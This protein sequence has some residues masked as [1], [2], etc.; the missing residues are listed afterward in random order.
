MSKAPLLPASLER[1]LALFEKANELSAKGWSNPEIAR[2]LGVSAGAVRSWARG[3]KPKRVSK[4][5][6]DLSPCRDL[7]YLAGFYL[8]DGKRA[9][10]ENKVRFELAD[11]EQVEHVGELVARILHREP[12]PWVRVRTFYVIDY[13]SVVLY[14]F[15]N[16]P[17][18][19]LADYLCEF[20]R[21]FLR[22]FFDAEGYCTCPLNARLRKLYSIT[23]GIANSKIRNLKVMGRLLRDLGLSYS[24]RRTNKKGGKMTIGGK[25]WIRRHDV[26]HLTVTGFDRARRFRDEVNFWN[27]PKATKLAD[28]VGLENMSP[29]ARYDWFVVHY[30]KR[31][32]KWV[33]KDRWV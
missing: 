14:E 27:Q 30:E 12:K 3:K 11:A 8:G 1:R 28:L 5:E 33:R 6:P 4:Y 24:V 25:T 2:R 15:L 7:A 20:E 19:R 18:E 17:V 32:R 10:H 9:G 29:G 23:V 21:D 16:Q 31:G 13:D 22:G 26:Y